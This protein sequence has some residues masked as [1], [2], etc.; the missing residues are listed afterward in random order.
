MAATP[1]QCLLVLQGNRL[2][3]LAEAV[4][5]W[6]AQ[7]PLQPLEEEVI[8]V[9][10]NAMA[11]WFKMA[12][13]E[14]LGVCAATRV[15][16]PARFIWRAYRAVLGRDA[17]PQH[18][19]LDKQ[20]LTWLLMR[21]LPQWAQQPGFEPVAGFLGPARDSS[22]RLQL[23]ER[24]ADVLDHY[25]VYRGDWL[26]AWGQGQDQL[27]HPLA[28][29]AHAQVPADQAWQ[30]ALWRA[31][32]SVLPAQAWNASRPQLHQRFVHALQVSPQA[33][34]PRLRAGAQGLPRRVVLFGTTQLPHQTLEAMTALA[35]HCQV[36]MAV[37]NPCRFHW[38]DT[39]SGRELLHVAALRRPHK[40]LVDTARV[41]PEDLHAH[42][43]PLLVAWGRQARDFV[44]QLDALDDALMAR[45]GKGLPRVE[46]F[47]EPPAGAQAEAPAR[48]W[49][50]QVQ[51]AIRDLVPLHE[52]P[53]PA[54]APPST[55]RS[56][57]FH[58]AHGPQREVEVLHDQLL[59]LLT[60]A[61]AAGST[62]HAVQPREVVVMVPDINTFAPAIRA[63]FGQ[64]P[65]GHPR[66]IPWGI[67]D[68][69]QRL[70]QPLLVA[71]EGV[72]LRAPQ[73]RFTASTVLG[74]LEL[75]GVARRFGLSADDLPTLR[76]WVQDAGVR[77]GLHAQQRASLGLAAMGDTN[78]WHFGLQRMLMGYATGALLGEAP[79]AGLANIEPH[80]EVAGLEASLAGG[81]ADVLRTLEQWWAEAQHPRP[82]ERWAERLRAVLAEVFEP[83][84]DADRAVLALL[85]EALAAWLQ[86]CE[87][88]G[89][90]DAVDLT[91]AREAWLG[92]VDD[93]GAG[94]RFRAGGVTFCTLLPL[95]AVPFEVVCLLGMN[96]GDYPRRSP[97]SDFDLMALPGQARAGDRSRR[98]DDRQLM[99]EALLA[100]RRVLYVSWCGRSQRDNAMQ[101]PSVLVAQLRDYLAAGWSQQAVD[102]RTTEHPLQPFSR[103]Y[104]EAAMEPQGAPGPHGP[105][106]TRSSNS[107]FTYASEWAAA[108]DAPSPLQHGIVGA[109]ARGQAARLADAVAPPTLLSLRTLHDFL[110]NP[111]KAHFRH[112]LKVV[113]G[114]PEDITADDELFQAAGLD[115]WRLLE[116]A[117]RT[118]GPQW[119]KAGQ[120]EIAP[121]VAAHLARVQRSGQLPL[122]G[123]GEA[124]TQ[125]LQDTLVAMLQAA[126]T[127]SATAGELTLG[128]PT[129]LHMAVS[130]RHPDIP[131]LELTDSVDVFR[132][133]DEPGGAGQ[134]APRL[135]W[136]ELSA[137]HMPGAAKRAPK[138][139]SEGS[140][141][142]GQMAPGTAYRHVLLGAWLRS[143]ACA[144]M[145]AQAQGVV[146]GR[147]ALVRVPALEQERAQHELCDLMTTWHEAMQAADP[148][149]TAAKTGLAHLA[150][151]L[152]PDATAKVYE[153]APHAEQPAEGEEASLARVYPD[154]D[155]L[156]A[157]GFEAASQRLYGAYWAWLKE[158]I[159][160]EPF[161]DLL[162]QTPVASDA[163]RRAGA[164]GMAS[165]GPDRT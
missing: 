104:F 69:H 92:G 108:F 31:V 153:R 152:T 9:P 159:R 34:A 1:P 22:R 155:S 65:R 56:I 125:A 139:G 11:E 71:L 7:R 55:D 93:S 60:V 49:L 151:P 133:L 50:Q 164:G 99:L 40:G 63:V 138:T 130:L 123:P 158:D 26:H 45:L 27:P 113:W 48:S 95:R 59:H 122:G 83:V 162:A 90:D 75:P 161:E 128:V 42:G 112:R 94:Q 150:H 17:V 132:A 13:A 20:A 28:G 80:A 85:D 21:W 115:T 149:P 84:D 51:D 74:L 33:L 136:L 66:H 53:G 131:Q 86:A 18:S 39:L 12:M 57:V 14:R 30:P 8:L 127:A 154:F 73:Q 41:V 135:R 105:Q 144:A 124:A 107:V 89:F 160:I 121:I 106:P 114:A 16:L 146:V 102:A 118:L 43:H 38:A 148:W 32:R 46:L 61:D 24:L 157:K 25:Q 77:W 165:N 109:P 120:A 23:A 37:P 10:S 100:A 163:N 6:L 4:L 76:A 29:A 147:D 35:A 64:H 72:L 54:G 3:L 140:W 52:H 97:R 129:T 79:P 110:R 141:H 81:L 145:G 142:R 68:Q 117:V 98:D 87:V 5:D 67:T 101:P 44:R 2:E 119:R 19:P 116:D 88:A 103:R 96:D 70:H 78:S 15:E 36:L 62:A 137:G 58:T 47:D 143:L 156:R 126:G 111:V 82:P 134:G 91:V